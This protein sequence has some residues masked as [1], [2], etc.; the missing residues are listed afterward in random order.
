MWKL[1]NLHFHLHSNCCVSVDLKVTFLCACALNCSKQVLC[2]KLWCK[3]T[4]N[5]S[6]AWRLFC[7]P[8]GHQQRCYNR[9]HVM[10]P[11]NYTQTW[12]PHKK[13]STDISNRRLSNSHKSTAF[14]QLITPLPFFKQQFWCAL[15]TATIIVTLNIKQW[16]FYIWSLNV[17]FKGKVCHSAPL[18]QT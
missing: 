12:A 6:R 13:P 15:Q 11:L 2:I 10:G 14:N 8:G 17:S 7:L 3:R 9:K 5:S 1:Y 18:H 16:D 4:E